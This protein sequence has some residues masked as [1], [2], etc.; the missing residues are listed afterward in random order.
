LRLPPEMLR[1][2][3]RQLEGATAACPI[4]SRLGGHGDLG[5]SNILIDAMTGAITGVLDWSSVALMDP[6]LDLAAICTTFDEQLRQRMLSADRNLR[7]A[8]RRAQE[9]AQTFALQ[10][11]IYGAEGWRRGRSRTWPR[12]VPDALSRTASSL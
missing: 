12:P 1:L 9:Y 7:Y 6:A 10:E 5:G 2:A 8:Y 11:A 3:E 4:S